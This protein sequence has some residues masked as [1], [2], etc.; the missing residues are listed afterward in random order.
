MT[1]TNDLLK[2]HRD[3]WVKHGCSIMSDRWSSKTNRT[4]INFLVNCPIGTMF[5]KSIDASSIIKTGEKTFKLFDEFVEYVGEANIVQVITDNGSNFK[6]AGKLLEAKRPHLYWT[7]CAAHCIDL[8]L[9]DIGKIPRVSKV[10]DRAI[11]MT[12]YIYN[13]IGVLNMMRE[14]TKQRE[15]IRPRKT[16]F[17]TSYL[18]LQCIHKHKNSLRAMFTSEEWVSSKWAKEIKTKRVV[19]TVLMPSF[20]NGVVYI[21]KVMG[22][23][24]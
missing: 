8:I 18:T 19:E 3:A 23:L 7:P 11:S 1:Y 6:L 10:L 17:C 4:L 16:R 13:H 14:F 2:N 20:W 5:V 24:V 21:L 15:L 12:N 22:P 9:E